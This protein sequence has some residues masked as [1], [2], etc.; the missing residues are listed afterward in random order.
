[1]PNLDLSIVIV[2]DAK[3]SSTVV[4]KTLNAAG[5]RDL[6][7]DNAGESALKHIEKR[8]TSVLV[9]DWIMTCMERL[10]ITDNVTKIN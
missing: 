8:K 1:M 3:F 4:A 6:R 10:T 7:V 9:A 5:Y 2:D